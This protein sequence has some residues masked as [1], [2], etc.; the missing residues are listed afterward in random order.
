MIKMNDHI[1]MVSTI[2]WSKILLEQK[3]S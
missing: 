3:Q 2:A 1:N